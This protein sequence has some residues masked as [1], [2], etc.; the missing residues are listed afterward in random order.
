MINK[1]SCRKT[2]YLPAL[3]AASDVVLA[4]FSAAFATASTSV[5]DTVAVPRLPVTAATGVSVLLI[6]VDVTFLSGLRW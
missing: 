2:V 3:A 4:F 6:V 1:L 5:A